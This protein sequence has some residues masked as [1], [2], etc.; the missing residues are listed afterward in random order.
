VG[1]STTEIFSKLVR[2]LMASEGDYLELDFGDGEESV[3]EWLVKD[4]FY[5]RRN[6]LRKMCGYHK[7]QTLISSSPF[8]FWSPD[9]SS[10]C[11]NLS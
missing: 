9:V 7:S 4:E 10:Y 1:N 6:K 3:R 5:G 2:V 11:F 8:P